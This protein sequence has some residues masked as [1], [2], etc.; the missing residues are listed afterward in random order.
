MRTWTYDG[1]VPGR[2]LR[3]RAGK[4]VTVLLLNQLPADTGAHPADTTVHWHG[5]RV[6]NSMDGVPGVTQPP[7]APGEEFVYQFTPPD[8]GTFW[9]H[10]HGHLQLDRG[11]YAPLIVEDPHEPG[12]YDV[13]WVLVLDDW[14]D[15]TGRTPDDVFHQLKRGPGHHGGGHGDKHGGGHGDMG[16]GHDHHGGGH[17]GMGNGN[18]HGDMGDGHGGHG[19]M[20]G[21]G[22]GDGDG[23]GGHGDMGGMGHGGGHKGGTCSA[24]LGMH[25]S[26]VDDYPYY[27]INGRVRE[28]PEVLRAKPGQRVRLRII[29]ASA[30]TMFR[31]ALG[32]HRFMVTHTDGFPVRHT[33]SR[34]LL[35]GMGE[36]VDAIVEL[37]DG[38]FPFVAR[39]EGK[40]GTARALVRTG[41]GQPPPP[42][43]HPAE[44]D[45]CPLVD[46]DLTGADDV[47]FDAAAADRVHR[48]VLTG[49]M[50]GFTWKINGEVFG[51]HTPLPISRG[52]RVRL[53]LINKTMMPHPMHTHGHTF[54]VLRDDSIPGPRRD[55]TI[56]PAQQRLQVQFDA[57]NPGDW[58]LHCHN[59]Y[60]M[61][62]GM[63]TT[64]T[65]T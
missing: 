5:V 44:L 43:L 16:G 54:Q 11:L 39:P 9:L 57:D 4:P 27:V 56:V 29:N 53:T 20:G 33:T 52:E 31:V 46:A 17:S 14:V 18:G 15:G 32:E 42:D 1:R 40:R 10:S 51:K 37:G 34:S 13:E 63:M 6:V 8:S 36:R 38:I 59:D 23:H 28:S 2:E 55:T 35:L 21:M 26:D 65:Y 19:D 60:H 24:H 30:D 47:T 12:E 49:D 22:G 41:G 25:V 50:D 7:V 58:A 45:V 61:A 48:V 64:L 3:V 62:A